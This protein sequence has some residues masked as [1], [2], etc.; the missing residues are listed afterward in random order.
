[1]GF[2]AEVLKD[3]EG[4]RLLYSIGIVI[5]VT[6]FVV[7]LI[8]T[9]RIRKKDLISYKTAILDQEEDSSKQINYAKTNE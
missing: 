8:R 4:I 2:V 5:F 1:M 6:L 9:L 7:I 3:T